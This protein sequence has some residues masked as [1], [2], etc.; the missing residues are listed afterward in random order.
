M[1]P[2]AF[3]RSL[4]ISSSYFFLKAGEIGA[5]IG[6]LI[7]LGSLYSLQPRLKQAAKL[8]SF[9]NSR[10]LLYTGWMN[11]LSQVLLFLK[12]DEDG[13]MGFGRPI[14]PCLHTKFLSLKQGFHFSE[15]EANDQGNVLLSCWRDR[16]VNMSLTNVGDICILLGFWLSHLCLSPCSRDILFMIMYLYMCLP[17]VS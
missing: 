8:G 13:A 16:S 7:F 2:K 9:S 1:L 5:N 4:S 12:M 17:A 14:Y 6:L 3:F 15:A 11:C 10:P